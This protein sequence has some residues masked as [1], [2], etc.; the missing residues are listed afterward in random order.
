M[1]DPVLPVGLE[2]LSDPQAPL[3]LFRA[4]QQVAV[5]EAEPHM[6]DPYW[7][8]KAFHVLFAE[9]ERLREAL[10]ATETKLEEARELYEA[11]HG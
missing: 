6:M 2:A 1:T 3:D 7:V 8:L 10:A 4:K 5:W 9:V 11:N